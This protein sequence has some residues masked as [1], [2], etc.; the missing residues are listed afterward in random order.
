MSKSSR[1]KGR[2]T[3][4][5]SLNDL[6]LTKALMVGGLPILT[7]VDGCEHPR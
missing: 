4:H 6:T 3:E 2:V 1:L 7:E 5:V